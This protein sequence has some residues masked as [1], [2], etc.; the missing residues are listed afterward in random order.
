MLSLWMF[1]A[2][3]GSAI[4][5]G[6]GLIGERDRA[7]HNQRRLLAE[8]DH[9]VKNQLATI[10]ALAERFVRSHALTRAWRARTG[11]RC[12]SGTS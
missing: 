8:L 9:R 5:T 3:V 4:L 2:A 11:S 1:L 12:R 6:G 10:I 7:L